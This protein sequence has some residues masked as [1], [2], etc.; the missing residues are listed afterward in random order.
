MMNSIKARLTRSFLLIIGL[1]LVIS[2][3][4]GFF[5]A[6]HEIDEM[7]DAQLVEEA[8]VLAG[9]LSLPAHD[10]DWPL[11]QQALSREPKPTESDEES[12]NTSYTKK[13]AVQVWSAEGLQLFR[14][15]SAPEE[16]FAELKPGFLIARRDG[17]VWHVYTTYLP[18]NRYWL[19]VGERTD[20]RRELS[21]N[22][23]ASLLVGLL[24]S[25][26]VSIVL[27]R[28]RLVRDMSPLE[29]LRRNISER[30]LDH[31]QVIRLNDEPEE[32]RPVTEAINHLF[33]RVTQGVERERAFIAD[34]AHELRTPLSIIRLHAQNALQYP[35]AERKNRSL[36]KVILGVDRNTRVVQQLL[37]MARLDASDALVMEVA[38]VDLRHIVLQLVQEF[39]PV[40]E[41]KRLEL[42]MEAGEYLPSVPGQADLLAVLVRN[43]LENAVNYTPENGSIRI[44]MSLKREGLMIQV[45]DSGPGVPEDKLSQISQ[46]FVRAAPRD[47]QGTGLGLEI[48]GR[49]VRLHRGE[50]RFANRLAGGFSVSVLLPV[51]PGEEA[52]GA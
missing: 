37:M 29:E 18:S 6:R 22:V 49:I 15:V 20:I 32:I 33:D 25:L 48:V 16:A 36:E 44:A 31:L 3:V 40:L 30:R 1:A 51:T 13:V 43:L 8:H 42:V 19:M 21:L 23:A 38:A 35:D 50:I 24:A 10:H 39:R 26:L 27:L 34:A 28:Q 5:T 41:G 46:R 12:Y 45:E 7:F 17:K 9:M 4:L 52:P 11:L 2:V 14:S 47:I